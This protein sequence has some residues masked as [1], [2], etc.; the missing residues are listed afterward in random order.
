MARTRYT[1]PIPPPLAT[2]PA[3]ALRAVLSEGYSAE[4]LRHDVLAGLVV[5][6]AMSFVVDL[7][8]VR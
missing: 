1:H 5:A 6:Y 7:I 4:D 2:L 3:S 8:G